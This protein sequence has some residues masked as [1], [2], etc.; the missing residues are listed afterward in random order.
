MVVYV[1]KDMKIADINKLYNIQLVLNIYIFSTVKTYIQH[2]CKT[3]ASQMPEGQAS[4]F[5]V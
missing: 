3:F 2:S 5:F 1:R 4:F